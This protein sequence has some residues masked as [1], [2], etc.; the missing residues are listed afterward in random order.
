M[1]NFRHREGLSLLRLFACKDPNVELVYVSPLPLNTEVLQYY[2]KI[3]EI[4]GV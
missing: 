2:W 4:S 1:S 3:L